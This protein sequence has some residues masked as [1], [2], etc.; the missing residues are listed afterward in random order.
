[1]AGALDSFVPLDF[2]GKPNAVDVAVATVADGIEFDSSTLGGFGGLDGVGDLPSAKK[3]A[4]VGRT[5]G[6]TQGEITAFELDGVTVDYD[7]KNAVFD[8]IVEIASHSGLFS[9]GGDSGSL[10]VTDPD[11]QAVGLLFA[12]GS[13]GGP[14]GTGV[15]L[16]CPIE[17]V[18]SATGMQLLT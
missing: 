4:K 2:S 18:L 8:N 9:D 12:G 10:I 5:T 17:P 14:F 13:T 11:L 3:V 6:E 15:T 16:A 1:V 7:G